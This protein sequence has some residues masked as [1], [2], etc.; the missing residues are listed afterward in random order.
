MGVVVF[1]CFV[2]LFFNDTAT[3]EIYTLSLHDALPIYSQG[4]ARVFH[5][6]PLAL[7]LIRLRYSN[8]NYPRYLNS[9]YP[10]YLNSNYPRQDRMNDLRHSVALDSWQARP[11]FSGKPPA[12]HLNMNFE[13]KNAHCFSRNFVTGVSGIWQSVPG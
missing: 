12:G 10:R 13:W 7:E 3:T 9:N 1:F 4:S 2:F 8:S 11:S 6:R 5:P